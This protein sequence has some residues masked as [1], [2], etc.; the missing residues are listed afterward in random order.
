MQCKGMNKNNFR[1][2]NY[3]MLNNNDY[4]FH[5]CKNNRVDKRSNIKKG[6]GLEAGILKQFLDASY[7]FKKGQNIN[8]YIMDSSLSGERV[9][10]YYNPNNM[11]C[12]VVHRGTSSAKDIYNDGMLAIGLGK[13]TNRFKH[14]ENI[15]KEAEKKYK[16]LGYKIISLG[17]SL[18]SYLN[19][20]VGN[21]D[22]RINLNGAV[23]PS[24]FLFNNKVNKNTTN[25]NSNYDPVSVMNRFQ[26]DQNQIIIK[27]NQLNLLNQHKISQLDKLDK[28][29]MIGKGIRP[30]KRPGKKSKFITLDLNDN[31][32]DD[33]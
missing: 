17:H 11:T 22:E 10:V 4:C 5:H 25:I 13:Y 16:S 8:D 26:K 33:Y 18:G 28:N 6:K 3:T 2:S 19:N 29:L 1:C 21:L 24:E 30:K 14:S 27:D 12:V 20:N 31:D 32:D 7:S 15:Q 23:S 9:Q